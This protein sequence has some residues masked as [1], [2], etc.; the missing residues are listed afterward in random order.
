V[1]RSDHDE[2]R[3]ELR[4]AYLRVFGSTEGE[5]VLNHIL[6][7][8]CVVDA[9]VEFRTELEAIR[10]LERKNVGETIRKMAKGPSI[11]K[12]KPEVKTNE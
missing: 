3:L 6:N 5:R 10:A 8:I 1:N 9:V 2:S 4:N 7:Q 12:P 11:D